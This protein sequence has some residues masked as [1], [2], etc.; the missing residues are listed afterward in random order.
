MKASRGPLKQ[1]KSDFGVKERGKNFAPRQ[2]S[3]TCRLVGS[4]ACLSMRMFRRFFSCS[5][6]V[7]WPAA[8]KQCFAHQSPTSPA[9]SFAKQSRAIHFSTLELGSL[10]RGNCQ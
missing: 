8:R 1:T 10:M 5:F 6:S 7:P 4:R 9:N 3:L 2:H